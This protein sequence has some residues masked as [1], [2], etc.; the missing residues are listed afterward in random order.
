MQKISEKKY[1][2]ALF[3]SLENK[4]QKHTE[5]II[6][7]FIILLDKNNKLSVIDK[8][9]EEFEKIHNTENQIIDVETITATEMNDTQKKDVKKFILEKTNSKTI[10]I[11]HNI[12]KKILGGI[13]IKYGD[14]IIDSSIKNK[15]NNLK[16][17]LLK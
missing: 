15:L 8:I 6:K 9:I 12:S 16:I 11:T 7:N 3:R 14:R 5:E 1:A 4:D 17:E 13:I 2:L 10:N